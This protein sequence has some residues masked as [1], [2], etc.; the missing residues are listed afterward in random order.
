LR[1]SPNLKD[2]TTADHES[3]D[4]VDGDSSV[5][6]KHKSE[7]DTPDC[8]SQE[9]AEMIADSVRIDMANTNKAAKKSSN[10]NLNLNHASTFS[11]NSTN[12]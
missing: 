11:S 2:S 8:I 5:S 4:S 12:S 3:S 1:F 9:L 6:R 7:G 10:L